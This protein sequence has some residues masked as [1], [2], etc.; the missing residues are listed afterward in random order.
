MYINPK[1]MIDMPVIGHHVWGH[2]YVH[3]NIVL[4]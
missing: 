4:P 1:G 3:D 2:A